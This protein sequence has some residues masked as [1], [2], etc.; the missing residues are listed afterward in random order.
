MKWISVT[1]RLPKVGGD[2]LVVDLD[3]CQAVLP[4]SSRIKRWNE[5]MH[6]EKIIDYWD[7]DEV[8]HWMPLPEPPK[9]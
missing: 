8:T 6:G 5:D 7:T 1:D 2:Y 9:E 4:Y 3:G